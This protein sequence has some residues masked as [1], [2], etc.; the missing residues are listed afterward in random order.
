MKNYEVTFKEKSEKRISLEAK[1]K[2]EAICAASVRYLKTTRAN[3]GSKDTYEVCI[4]VNEAKQDIDE[5]IYEEKYNQ[6][7]SNLKNSLK[8]F[9]LLINPDDFYSEEEI[10]DLINSLPWESFDPLNDLEFEPIY[11]FS[12]EGNNAEMFDIKRGALFGKKGVRVSS[13]TDKTFFGM[14]TIT[15]GSEL[16][17]LE[18]LSLAATHFSSMMTNKDE[19]FEKVTYRFPIEINEAYFYDLFPEDFIED[20]EILMR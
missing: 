15:E 1:N 2:V 7:F 5:M 3:L 19:K 12:I 4:S 17:L 10:E 20:L 6:G 18:D 14:S 13:G 16:W 11:S 8:E 9:A